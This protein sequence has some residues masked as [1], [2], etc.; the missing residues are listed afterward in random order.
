MHD[1]RLEAFYV[2]QINNFN[3][4]PG[5][6]VRNPSLVIMTIGNTCSHSSTF[7]VY[8]KFFKSLIDVNC[9]SLKSS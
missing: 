4:L 2:R 3:S 7:L 5:S 1:N 9:F 8:A 6:K